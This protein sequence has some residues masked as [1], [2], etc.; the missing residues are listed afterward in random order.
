MSAEFEFEFGSAFRRASIGLQ[1]LRPEAGGVRANVA[2]SEKRRIQVQLAQQNPTM[3]GGE[4]N[5]Q[6]NTNGRSA[7]G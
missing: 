6:K 2:N 1:A 5:A 3:E 4:L 7:N